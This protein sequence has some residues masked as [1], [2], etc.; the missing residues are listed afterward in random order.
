MRKVFL[1]ACVFLVALPACLLSQ[2]IGIGTLTPNRAKLEVHGAAGS[3]NAIF[4]GDATGISIQRN[5]PAVGFNQYYTNTGKY[6][7]SGY[8]ALISQDQSIGTVRFQLFPNGVKDADMPASTGSLAMS[9]NGNVGIR[10]EPIDATLYVAKAGNFSGSAVFGGSGYNSHFHYDVTEDTYIRAGKSG[11]HVYI[12][13]ISGGK[14]LMGNGFSHVGINSGNP[15]YPFEI[16]QNLGTGIRVMQPSHSSNYWEIRLRLDPYYSPIDNHYMIYNG[17][18]KSLFT[19]GDGTAYYFSD[20]RL[21]T[22]IRGISS[23]MKKFMQL[24]PVQYNMKSFPGVQKTSGFIAQ[25]VE[26]LFPQLVAKAVSTRHG[27]KGVDDL[28]GLNYDGF[29][30]LTIRAIQE[31]QEKIKQ[32]QQQNDK[33]EKRIAAAE[34]LLIDN[35]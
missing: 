30:M 10:A 8:A 20:R 17:S 14:I 29:R 2:N 35:K 9:V 27:Y 28:Y 25:D 22:N 21:K 23:I 26:K 11:G 5:W 24:E 13:Q 16:R 3:T 32:M 4:G 7:A 1:S 12:N 34:A 15:T 31:Q 33:L 6:M 18:Y 19:G